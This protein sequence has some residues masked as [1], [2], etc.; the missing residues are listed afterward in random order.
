MERYRWNCR[1]INGFNNTEEC[2]N[3]EY[4]VSCLKEIADFIQKF[5][6][7]MKEYNPTL[8]IDGNELEES[9]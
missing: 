9:K 1:L 7:E 6:E 8:I 3:C 5:N 4:H 2:R